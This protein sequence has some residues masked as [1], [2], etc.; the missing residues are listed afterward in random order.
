MKPMRLVDIGNLTI[1]IQY[2]R[3]NGKTIVVDAIEKALN[4]LPTVDAIPV[5]FIEKR[6]QEYASNPENS[7][8]LFAAGV[9]QMIVTAWRAERE[10]E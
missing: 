7:A 9:I 3:C 10:R 1:K 6:A 8:D 5:E 4:E 2:P